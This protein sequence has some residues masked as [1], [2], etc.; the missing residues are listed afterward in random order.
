[1][2]CCLAF[3]AAACGGGGTGAT[4]TLPLAAAT[5]SSTTSSSTTTTTT[6]PAT[7]TSTTSSTT[8][9]STTSTT[10]TTMPSTTT[11]TTVAA[12]CPTAPAIPVGATVSATKSIDADGDAALDV[13]TTYLVGADWH[14]RVDFGAGGSADV[15]VPDVSPLT[16]ALALGAFDIEGDGTG[17]LFVKVDAG[18][19]AILVGLYDVDGCGLVPITIGGVPAVFP[20]GASVGNF[21]G[22]NCD[23][24]LLWTFEGTLI[25]GSEGMY[26]A[27]DIPYTLEGHVLTQGF[28]DGAVVSA[29]EIGPLLTCGDVD[30][31]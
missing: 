7:S 6:P 2:M 1:M 22:L 14:L 28:G 3:V 30:L 16:G 31:G 20:V 29:D 11:T 13:M 21:S 25:E 8:T 23:G 17:E 18:A 12:A 9:S 15:V 19:H 26:E 24:S 4:T 27:M 5:T 10:T